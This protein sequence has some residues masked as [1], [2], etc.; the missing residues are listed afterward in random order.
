MYIN[1]NYGYLAGAGD[2]SWNGQIQQNVPTNPA[3]PY[4]QVFLGDNFDG[5]SAVITAG[6]NGSLPDEWYRKIASMIV[7]G[8]WTFLARIAYN[9]KRAA[10]P[11]AIA[12]L[13]SGRYGPAALQPLG[14]YKTI[15][16]VKLVA[17]PA[18]AM[19][20]AGAAPAVNPAPAITSQSTPQQAGSPVPQ[21]LPQPETALSPAPT[22]P[23]S[24]T[25]FLAGV[26]WQKWAAIAAVG[27][28]LYTIISNQK[29]KRHAA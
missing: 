19:A 25:G 10:T 12:Q 23:P 1:R 16:Y 7:N 22:L 3:Q 21:F 6:S 14:L 2:N 24:T 5:P 17:P 9:S 18:I 28:V 29:G 8:D 11:D 26:D 13:S 4:V 20:S 15:S 27:G